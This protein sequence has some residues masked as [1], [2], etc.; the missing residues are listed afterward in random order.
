MSATRAAHAM[1]G[2]ERAFNQSMER[3]ATGLKINSAL[4]DAAGIAIASKMTSQINSLTQAIRNAND[5][6]SMLTTADSAMSDVGDMLQR[7]RE[8]SIQALNDSNTD[9]DRAALNLE[10]QALKSQIDNISGYTQ[11]NGKTILDGSDEDGVATF[12]IGANANQV[13]EIDTN[14]IK[15]AS[16]GDLDRTETT[17]SYRSHPNKPVDVD[18]T[19]FSYVHHSSSAPAGTETVL[20][21][22][23]PAS[24]PTIASE[25]GDYYITHPSESPSTTTSH[26]F[27]NHSATSPAVV[28]AS[29]RFATHASAAPPTVNGTAYQ[30]EYT[31]AP[32]VAV[33]AGG[34]I[35]HASAAPVDE[36][37]IRYDAHSSAAPAAQSIAAVAWLQHRALRL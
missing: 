6:V 13:I 23:H 18:Q 10:Y 2:S 32:T 3:L 19:A 7:M 35:A 20:Y 1:D 25:W 12:H 15:T 17:T 4:D 5:A 29:G 22:T 14:S 33:A 36:G 28:F 16:L 9:S 11:W 37:N 21:R 24:P 30:M 8:L 27:T 31:T 34:Y 26:H